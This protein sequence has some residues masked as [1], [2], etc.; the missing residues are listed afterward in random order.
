MLISL[1]IMAVH[2]STREPLKISST[3]ILNT[4]A[5]WASNLEGSALG[6]SNIYTAKLDFAP[7][8]NLNFSLMYNYAEED[9]WLNWIQ[10]NFFGIYQK[11]Q[12]TTVASINWFG[13]D[14]HELRL[15]A[16]MVGF[17][18]RDPKPYLRIQEGNLNSIETQIDPFTL[19]G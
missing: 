12:K 7:R 6:F 4:N 16:Q 18:A 11:K 15:K 13:G 19:S 5:K 3:T 9:D 17:T 2:F 10:D 1:R 8:D 14:K